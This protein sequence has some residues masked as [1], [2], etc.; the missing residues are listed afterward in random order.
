[1]HKRST[2]RG[3]WRTEAD[4]TF[5]ENLAFSQ[6]SAMQHLCQKSTMLLHSYNPHALPLLRG[7]STASIS[8]PPLTLPKQYSTSSCIISIKP[9]AQKGKISR[10]SGKTV[11]ANSLQLHSLFLHMKT[12][13]YLLQ[14]FEQASTSIMTLANKNVSSLQACY[15]ARERWEANWN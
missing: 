4:W 6:Q 7:N 11:A 12:L 9:P 2:L 13:L 5:R 10:I 1:M 3:C 14:A 15:T 8:A